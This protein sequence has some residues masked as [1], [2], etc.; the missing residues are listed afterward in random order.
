MTPILKRAVN[1]SVEYELVEAPRVD[2]H[3]WKTLDVIVLK[4]VAVNE[5]GEADSKLSHVRLLVC[6][7]RLDDEKIVFA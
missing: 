4:S 5:S 2:K 1:W 7:L 3:D 6:L